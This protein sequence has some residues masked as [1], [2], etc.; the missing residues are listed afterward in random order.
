MTR[1][2]REAVLARLRSAVDQLGRTMHVGLIPESGANIAYAIPE[3]RSRDDV[4]A[5]AG[6]IMRRGNEPHPD[7]LVA[8]GAS[9]HLATVVLTAMKYDPD[10]RSAA[11]IRY[12]PPIVAIL[13]DLLLEICSFDRE[14]EPPGVRTMDWG[15]AFCCRSGVPDIVFDRGALGREPFVRVL[16][17]DTG[18]VASII[19]RISARM[20]KIT[21][22]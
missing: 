6:T 4:A 13:E 5:I 1:D 15:V 22:T 10:I 8:F 9:D 18:A 11:V 20:E 12:S 7:G 17:E 14:R 16:A 3:A 19:G 2:A 21:G